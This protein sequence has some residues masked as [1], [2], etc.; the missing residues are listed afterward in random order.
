MCVTDRIQG[1]RMTEHTVHKLEKVARSGD[2]AETRAL[3][4]EI[5]AKVRTVSSD[6]M[7]GSILPMRRA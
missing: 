7:S 5:L 6:E 1:A 2:A 3:I 4:F